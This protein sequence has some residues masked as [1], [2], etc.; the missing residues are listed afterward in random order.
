M[1]HIEKLEEKI[2]GLVYMVINKINDKKYVGQTTKGLDCRKKWHLYDYKIRKKTIPAFYNALTKYGKKNFNWIILKDNINIL[3]IDEKEK[4]WIVR[5]KPKTISYN[6]L[7]NKYFLEGLSAKDISFGSGCSKIH[8]MKS[9]KKFEILSHPIRW[10]SEKKRIP[11]KK[12]HDKKIKKDSF[13]IQRAINKTYH[14]NKMES[15]QCL[16]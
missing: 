14:K 4:Q 5:K 15:E 8:I 16:V 10:L 6:C 11:I 1:E 13:T 12:I 9:L 7:Y 3:E 2:M